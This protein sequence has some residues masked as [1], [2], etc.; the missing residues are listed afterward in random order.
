MD[1]IF[2]NFSGWESGKGKKTGN[3]FKPLPPGESTL[4]PET[5]KFL[6]IFNCNSKGYKFS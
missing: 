1:W 5:R 3:R 2:M 4:L 6:F